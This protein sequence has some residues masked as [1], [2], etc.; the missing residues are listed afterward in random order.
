MVCVSFAGSADKGDISIY[1]VGAIR[2][3][4]P[5]F[6]GGYPSPRPGSIGGCAPPNPA[7]HFWTPKSEPKNRQNQGFGFLCLNRSLSDLGHLCH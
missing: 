5:G 2:S 4:T 1:F 3:H 7:V 6:S